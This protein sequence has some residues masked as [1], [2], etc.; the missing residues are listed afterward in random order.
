MKKGINYIKLNVIYMSE[1]KR[2][3]LAETGDSSIR[4]T[5]T[6]TP[7]LG[8]EPKKVYH[9]PFDEKATRER[10]SGIDPE[11][12]PYVEEEFAYNQRNQDHRKAGIGRFLRIVPRKM[13]GLKPDDPWV[14]T[15]DAE[16]WNITRVDLTPKGGT[17]YTLRSGDFSAEIQDQDGRFIAV[18]S[19]ADVTDQFKPILVRRQYEKRQDDTR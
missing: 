17:I 19:G 3:S 16:V 12:G 7:R 18:D 5:D 6:P 9:N 10:L 8:K 1:K 15:N 13:P 2:P 14:R 11:R 4:D